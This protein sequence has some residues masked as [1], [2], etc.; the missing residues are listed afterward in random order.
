M[1]TTRCIFCSILLQCTSRLLLLR[2]QGGCDLHLTP[3]IGQL[4]K[5]LL[6]AW[7]AKRKIGGGA[8]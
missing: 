8:T 1:R 6:N 5:V 3:T 7:K 2:S 4:Y